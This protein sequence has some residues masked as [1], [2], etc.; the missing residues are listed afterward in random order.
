M[1]VKRRSYKS[2]VRERSANETHARILAAA[3]Q[4][5]AGGRQLPAFSLD[6]VAKRANVSR[7]TVY[8]RFASKR[9]LL[10]A[11]FDETAANGG[12]DQIAG[13]LTG[14]DGEEAITRV[15]C[16]FCDFWERNARVFPAIHAN[17][18][19]DEEIAASLLERTERRRA[20]LQTIIARSVSGKR[21]RELVDLLFAVTSLDVHQMLRRRGHSAKAAKT[22]MLQLVTDIMGRYRR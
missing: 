11:V 20:V 3:R 10:E 8:N 7:L 19:L 21:A 14:A 15:V 17:A 16:V 18:V 9:G 2:K 5:L 22:M 12:L 1:P 4:L 13:I 6:A